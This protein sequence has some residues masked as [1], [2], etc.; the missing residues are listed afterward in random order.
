MV[1]KAKV[2]NGRVHLDAPTSLPEGTELELM[3]VDEAWDSLTREERVR[4][5]RGSFRH[6]K[7]GVNEFLASKHQEIE[8]N[9]DR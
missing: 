7:E 3:P 8:R 1:L 5:L 9:P 6:L 4:A 2:I